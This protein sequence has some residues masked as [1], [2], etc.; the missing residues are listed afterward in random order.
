[1]K[2]DKSEKWL[3]TNFCLPF[4]DQDAG[5]GETQAARENNFNFKEEPNWRKNANI[6][7]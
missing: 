5:R 1:M 4:K 2:V 3:L 6:E 7:R